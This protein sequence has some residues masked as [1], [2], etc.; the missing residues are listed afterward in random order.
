MVPGAAA[1]N[2]SR[3]TARVMALG[4]AVRE[5]QMRRMGA[6]W[7]FR[8]REAG[9]DGRTHLPAMRKPT[10]TMGR[11]PRQVS[12]QAVTRVTEGERLS[13]RDGRGGAICPRRAS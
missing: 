10:P 7:A 4:W 11:V 2:A 12:R 5:R 1:R 3:A 9:P 13:E 6:S 8:P